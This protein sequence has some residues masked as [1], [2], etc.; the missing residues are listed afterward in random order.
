MNLGKENE[1]IEFKKSASLVKEGLQSVSA[2]LNKNGKGTL[3]FGVKDSGDV[4]G[5]QIGNDTLNKL[6]QELFNQIK[7]SFFYTVDLKNTAEGKSFI[8]VDFNGLNT[9]Y[10]AYGRYYLRFHDEDRIM[11]N[12]LLR[13][14]YLSKRKDYCHHQFYRI[15]RPKQFHTGRIL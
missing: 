1:Y 9:P 15:A 4:C 12:D 10:S 13:D 14:F 8:Q 6:S 11:D 2:I 7:P 5:L 3:Y